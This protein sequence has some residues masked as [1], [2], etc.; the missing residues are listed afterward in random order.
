MQGFNI[1]NNNVFWEVREDTSPWGLISVTQR[2]EVGLLW[3]EGRGELNRRLELGLSVWLR[4]PGHPDRR[5]EGQTPD[6]RCSLQKNGDLIILQNF[7]LVGK[8]STDNPKQGWECFMCLLCSVQTLQRLKRHWHWG[9]QMVNTDILSPYLLRNIFECSWGN[10]ASS[11]W[12]SSCQK[13]KATISL[14]CERTHA[15]PGIRASS[16]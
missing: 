9:W 7:R 4:N 13:R 14:S 1:L 16:T 10:L 5:G 15:T 12:K 6:R 11:K 3:V 2:A 8:K